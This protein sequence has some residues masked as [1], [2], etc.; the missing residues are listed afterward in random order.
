MRDPFYADYAATHDGRLPAVNSAPLVR[1]AYADSFPNTTVDVANAN[2]TL[3]GD[4]VSEEVLIADDETCSESLLLYVGSQASANYR[5]EYGDGPSIPLGFT[6][7]RISPFW[8]G[9][10]FV[11]PRK[12]LSSN[13]WHIMHC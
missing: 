4:W 10:D 11:V 8:G 13:D 5:N 2:R 1:W 9:P 3:F 6:V 12:S 7:S